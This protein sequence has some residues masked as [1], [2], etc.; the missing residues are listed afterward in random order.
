MA[1]AFAAGRKTTSE[2]RPH[3]GRM[4]LCL[5]AARR[6]KR[7]LAVQGCLFANLNDVDFAHLDLSI[8]QPK[9]IAV[10]VVKKT[11]HGVPRSVLIPV[12]VVIHLVGSGTYV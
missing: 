2:A 5:V 6:G 7:W 12:E 9:M 11:G 4:S 10:P 1:C 3:R 8:L